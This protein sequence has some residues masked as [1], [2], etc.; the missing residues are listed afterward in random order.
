MQ[1]N[2]YL[3]RASM[4]RIISFILIINFLFYRPQYKRPH[5]NTSC[6][7]CMKGT[8]MWTK[9][10]NKK[11][12]VAVTNI[13]CNFVK[14]FG[15]IY[16]MKLSNNERID[17]LSKLYSNFTKFPKYYIYVDTN[18]CIVKCV[19]ITRNTENRTQKLICPSMHNIQ[20]YANIDVT[21]TFMTRSAI[22]RWM[23]KKG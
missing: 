6:L 14:I 5:G 18:Y 16:L 11:T 20:I 22:S 7:Y 12:I 17:L 19:H 10:L 21:Q 1:R 2:A 13:K 15:V 4:Q 9:N 3:Y 8:Q 23:G